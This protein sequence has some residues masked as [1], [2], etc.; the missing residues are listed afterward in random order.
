MAYMVYLSPLGEDFTAAAGAYA[1]RY[2]LE[3]RIILLNG[4]EG[5]NEPYTWEQFTDIVLGASFVLMWNGK[6]AASALLGDL[7]RRKSI[8][9]AFLE[10]GLM[11]QGDTLTIDPKGFNGDSLL[12]QPLDWV[13]SS[14]MDRL[15][16]AR[17]Q[18]QGIYP[19]TNNSSYLVP[20]QIPSDTQILYYCG[21]KSMGEFG[22]YVCQLLGDR[23][24]FRQ[25]PLREG[26]TY[27][28][29]NVVTAQ[30][31]GPFF[32][33]AAAAQSVVGLTSTCLLEAAILGKPVMALGD[34]PLRTHA[35]H[36]RVAA[37]AL[38][39]RIPRDEPVIAHVLE[40]HGV[41]PLGV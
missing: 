22:D 5:D 24:V 23:V 6:Q 8:P 35:D 25:H 26:E 41:I 30:Q 18:L 31:S 10:Y 9:C 27:G 19:F 39:M 7:C 1:L 32:K 21:F 38:S 16:D 11:P 13:Q 34:H 14:D 40:R 3:L 36:D 33:H 28:L 2:N 29:P 17:G 15:H 37:A 20:L 12:C 4:V